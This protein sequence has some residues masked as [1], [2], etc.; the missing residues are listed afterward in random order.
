MASALLLDPTLADRVRVVAMA[1]RDLT[2]G[3]ASEYNEQNDPEAWRLLLASRTP[4]VVG[5]GETCTRYLSLTFDGARTLLRNHGPVA[6]WLWDDYQHWYFAHVKPLRVNDFSKS[7][8]IWDIITLA[9]L[10]DLATAVPAPRPILDSN[11]TFQAPPA[12]GPHP[13]A[14]FENITAVNTTGLWTSFLA[15]LDHFEATHRLTQQNEAER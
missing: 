8:V 12:T 2:P 7:W 9:Y 13:P 6:D 3:G 14:S 4:V 15:G 10:R 5:T 11:M 1:F